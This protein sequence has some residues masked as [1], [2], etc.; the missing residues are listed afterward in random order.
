M[1]CTAA[2]HTGVW[3]LLTSGIFLTY[4][5]PRGQLTVIHAGWNACYWQISFLH[6][7]ILVVIFFIELCVHKWYGS[8]QG[9]C[10]DSSDLSPTLQF[11]LSPQSH[12]FQSKL[13]KWISLQNQI[14][15]LFKT[16]QGECIGNWGHWTIH[17][18]KIC[19]YSYIIQRFLYCI[20]A[21]KGIC[22]CIYAYLYLYWHSS[23]SS[24][25][26]QYKI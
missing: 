26:L 11:R 21:Q 10:P 3:V 14:A 18:A 23:E 2:W 17:V 12:W 4:S 16:F 5:L 7:S 13:Q 22:I 1:T 24:K 25:N 9:L 20:V 8:K 6:H 19:V 15:W